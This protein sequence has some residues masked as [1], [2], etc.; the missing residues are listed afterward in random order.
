MHTLFSQRSCGYG[1][2]FYNKSS[3]GAVCRSVAFHVMPSLDSNQT[4]FMG[5][6]SFGNAKSHTEPCR[7]AIE[8]GK[9][10]ECCVCGKWSLNQIRRMGGCVLVINFCN[11]F[12]RH[13]SHAQ[14]ISQNVKGRSNAYPYLIR[15]YGCSTTVLRDESL[16][17]LNDILIL[18][19]WS[20]A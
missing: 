10:Q 8:P 19:C 18:S 4:P 16:R 13:P 9:P 1:K 7:G 17:L 11:E 5:I 15:K 14:I 2:Y 12:C 3:G 6:F 20:S